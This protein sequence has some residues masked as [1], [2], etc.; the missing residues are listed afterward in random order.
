MSGNRNRNT[1]HLD[2]RAGSGTVPD[3]EKLVNRADIGGGPATTVLA[4]V[5]DPTGVTYAD[6]PAHVDAPIDLDAIQE[7]NARIQAEIDALDVYPED[8]PITVEQAALTETR[9]NEIMAE[10]AKRARYEVLLDLP[11]RKMTEDDEKELSIL[12]RYFEAAR[13]QVGLDVLYAAWKDKGVELVGEKEKVLEVKRAEVAAMQAEIDAILH[14]DARKAE[15]QAIDAYKAS[16]LEVYGVSLIDRR[17]AARTSTQVVQADKAGKLHSTKEPR[18]FTLVLEGSKF[19]IQDLTNASL[20]GE[21]LLEQGKL[22]SDVAKELFA[23]LNVE[24]TEYAARHPHG[25]DNAN[26]FR[27]EVIAKD[28]ARL[29]KQNG[30]LGERVEGGKVRPVIA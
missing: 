10:N 18:P 23:G 30:K 8:F 7:E 6:V 9:I 13:L 3:A 17:Y 14:G 12:R 19:V 26:A 1:T 16:K 28:A 29:L 27:S 15:A 4:P 11:T 25:S 24:G 21:S 2:G 5:P 20:R 22:L